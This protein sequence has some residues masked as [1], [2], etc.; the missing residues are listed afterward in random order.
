M[1]TVDLFKVKK[2]W[3]RPNTE[4]SPTDPVLIESQAQKM[5]DVKK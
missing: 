2:F 5:L 3:V 4:K 1:P